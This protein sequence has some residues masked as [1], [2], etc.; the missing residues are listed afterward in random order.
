MSSHDNEDLIDYEDEN[1]LPTNGAAVPS[2]NGAA[3]A[4]A[5][6]GEG[7]KEK[8]NFS[9][10]HS[11]GFRD[12]LLKPELLRAISDLGFEHPSEVQQECIPQAVLG[13]DVL[14]QAK[15]GHGKT[16]VFV[17]ATLQQLEPVNGEVSVLVLCHTRELAFQIKN[18]Y[19]RFAK[20]MPDV[21]VST[22]YGGT[23]VAK[24]SEILRDKTKCP[25][26]VVATPGRLNAL[27]R[28]KVLDAKNVKHFVL[29]ECDKMLEQLD[30][31]R[32]V[33]EIFRATPH[34][35]QVMMF[36]ATLAKEI[37]V[38]CKKFMANPLEIFV[39]DETKLT[40]HGLQQHYVKLE[41]T[42]KN[43]KLNE[44]LD[45]LE[46]NQVVIFVKSVARAIELDKLLVSCNFPSISIHSG[47]QQE[48]RIKRYTAFK[49]FEKRILVATDIFGRGIDVERVNIVVNY[50]CPP[51]A[52]SYLH[53][54][55][56]AGRFGT[57]GLAIT[58]VS[59]ESDQQVMAAIQSRFEVAVSELPEHIDPASYRASP[60][61]DTGSMTYIAEGSSIK[62]GSNVLAKI[63]PAHSNGSMCL[64]REAH[65]LSRVTSSA[66]A[67][68]TT[69]RLIDFITIPRS[70]GD[71]VVLL[72]SHPGL[73]LLGRYFPPSKVNDFLLAD[74]SKTRTSGANDD[75]FVIDDEELDTL[76]LESFDVMDLASFLEFAIQA[77][78]CLEIIHR[79]GF[80]H[81]E[82]RANAFHLNSHSG[83]VRFVHFGNRAVS[84]EEFG[85]PS[86]LV[87]RALDETEKTKVKEALCYLAPEQT[88]SMEIVNQDHRTDLY[89]L[90]MMFWTLLVGRGMMPFEG[91]P[92]EL[93]HSIVQKRPMPVHEIRRD[94]PMVLANIIDKLLAKSPDSR[95]QSAYGL[96]A[97]LLE[98]QRRLLAAVSSVLGQSYELIPSFDIATQDRYM[99]FTIPVTL[100]GR[101]K[102]L[103]TIRH[104][105]KH[106]TT[107]FSRHFSASRGVL[108]V[109]SAG[110]QEQILTSNNDKEDIVTDTDSD[111]SVSSLGHMN[112]EDGAISPLT[113]MSL[114]G[115]HSTAFSAP[116]AVDFGDVSKR[117]ANKNKSHSVRAHT[118]MVV[119]HP[120]D[121]VGKSSLVLANQAKWRSH[122]LWGQAKFQN[123]D[124]APFAAL[125]GCLSSVLRQL[126][127]FHTDLHRFVNALKERLGPQLQNIPLLYQGTPELRDILGIFDIDIEIPSNKDRLATL[128]L[129]ARSL[130]LIETLINSRSRMLIFGTLRSDVSEEYMER[131]RNMCSNKGRTTWV[132]V[133]PLSFPALGSL[134]SKTLHQEEES[135]ADLSRFIYTA[136]CGNAFVARNLLTTFQ[137]QHYITFD[138]GN[139][140]WN[141]DIAAI[142][143]SFADQKTVADPADGSFLLNHFRELPEEAQKYLLWASFFGATFKVTEV[144]L[145]MDWERTNDNGGSDEDEARSVS[146]AVST[147]QEQEHHTTSARGS[148]RGLQA[149]ISEG[150]L[151]Q[152][153]RDMCSFAHDRYRQAVQVEAN[154]LPGPAISNMSFRIFTELQSMLNGK[155]FII[156]LHLLHDH[157]KWGE[158]LNVL[159][160]AGDS[161]WA[162]GAH[163]LALQAFS[164]AK[165]LLR[166]NAWDDNPRR[167]LKQSDIL[168]EECVLKAEHPEDKGQ[169]LRLRANNQWMRNN[170][171][172]ALKDTIYALH[173]LGVDVN[174]A[175]SIEEA[176][177]M[178][179]EVK[180][181]VLAMGYDKIIRIPRAKDP[182]TDLAVALLND[183]GN[184]AY[185]SPGEGFA[186][187]IG[188]TGAI[189]TIRVALQ[190]G[191]SPGTPLGF[192]WALGAAAER[193][194]LF[195][196]STD[197]GKLALRIADIHGGSFDKCRANVLFAAL[198]APYDNMHIRANLPRLEEALKYGHSAGDRGFTSFASIHTIIT[199][200]YVCDHL[201]EVV[202][203]AEE[204]VSDIELWTPEGEANILAKDT[205]SVETTFDTNMCKEADFIR[206]IQK[207]SGNLGLSMSWYNA[208][209]VVALFCVGHAE[210]SAELGFSVYA[211]RSHH[212][213]HRHP[214]Y[215]AFFH[216]LALIACL[217]EGKTPEGQ[218][219]RYMGQLRLNQSY[220]RKWL[221]PSPINTSTWVALVDAELASL[222]GD[223]EALKLYDT[224]VK[225]AV[226]DNWH[227]EEGWALYMDVI[228]FET[229]LRVWVV[230]YNVVVYCG[231]HNGGHKVLYVAIQ[232][233]T[234]LASFSGHPP[235]LYGSAPKLETSEE[236]EISSLSASDLASILKWSKD[237]SSD[238][239]LSSALQRLT[240]IATE[241]SRSQNTCLVITS[242]SG[243][244][245]VATS[246][247]TPEMC[248]VYEN[249]KSVRSISDPLQKA[250]IQ[251][252]ICLPIFSNRGQTYGAIYVSSKY[253][254]SQNT[255]TILTLLC[256]QAS[257]SISS[258]LLF[259]SVQAGTRENLKMI[260][261]QR[262]ALET[263]RKSR[264][265]ALK[266]TKVKIISIMIKSNFL[267]SM[268]HELR[269]PFSSFYGLLDLL[270]GTE[271]N[272]GQSEI[273]Y[274]KLEASAVKLEFS[275]FPVENIIADCMELLSPM[276][277]KKLDLSFNI[278]PDV[279]PWIVSDYARIRQVLMN[280]IGNAVKFTASG[281]VTVV[282]SVEKET[283]VMPPDIE[284]KFTIRDTGIGLSPSAVDLLFVP[285][286]QADNSSTRRFGGT[287]LGLSI[288]RQLVK[289][290]G[291]TIGVQ[292]E[293]NSGSV[294]WFTL[295]VKVYES[296]DSRKALSDIERLQ[297]LLK[298]PQTP[299]ILICS[300]SYATS[301][302]LKMM[303][304]GF[305][306]DSVQ[307]MEEVKYNLR[308]LCS[309][310]LPLDFLVLDDQSEKLADDLSQYIVSLDNKSLEDTKI[311]HLYTPTTDTLSGP[312]LSNST[313]SG[314]LRM[315]KPPRRARLLQVLAKLKNIPDIAPATEFKRAVEDSS[316]NQ[317]TLYG[318]V[319]IAEDN[320]V[321]Q[322]LLVKQ[323]ER[324]Q[325][326]VTATSNGEEA[327]K[328]WETREP[329]FFT[330]A[331]FDHRDL[332]SLLSMFGTSPASSASGD[333][334]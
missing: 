284:L 91:R 88:G 287:G 77:T 53:R 113:K 307:D 40:L 260:S 223:P 228:L 56:R 289:L 222:T 114:H 36:S 20:Y 204:C 234:V 180:N 151:V 200:L 278:E 218:R 101:E 46:F 132:Q 211:T 109:S 62:D 244:Y 25:H 248:V 182:R 288:S 186:D 17:L 6:D 162:R 78:H 125:L 332:L 212:P 236:Q 59:S 209:K 220:V 175:P 63:A 52:D 80:T 201:S 213:N 98:C 269:T 146:R 277:A 329:G 325:L 129:R 74:V 292:S 107:S 333:T 194:G 315:T 85:G 282:C 49:A 285:F 266:A 259:R 192:F 136:S 243:E 120:G 279:P 2:S 142:E 72:L 221:S 155:G 276:A 99:A 232:T 32:D 119:G 137:R 177:Q 238:I 191:M 110:S 168:A 8:K 257:I 22:F 256:Q 66:D 196:F 233:D 148:M 178:F 291:G 95:Y 217:R 71:C 79:A 82:V 231:S 250:V 57:K 172:A 27:A 141:H 264:E 230:N 294:F 154:D 1:D 7:D 21:R 163:E 47:L 64:E 330:V 83:V 298:T 156:C 197:L 15:S 10:I 274:S 190:R 96:K 251:H 11:T 227:L 143:A 68:S 60:W 42:G 318:N 89:S 31:R 44:L 317:R 45:T 75:I 300:Q 61:E 124:S 23:P 296:E 50:D 206:Y 272:P 295:P 176:D 311:I 130:D 247:V 26:I 12:F 69:L 249:Q 267:A 106:T 30:M 303:L 309:L 271:L 157:P 3:L 90:G 202:L 93:L 189:Q 321:A 139:N 118:I 254:F 24:D 305:Q 65:I 58:C 179:E 38:T 306:V 147:L 94:V 144:A 34:H 319:L 165:S 14:C 149:A 283:N 210:A 261:A 140:R 104:V 116:P 122:G 103:E 188:L 219:D 198:V 203:A 312:A 275:G 158:L 18:E 16:A 268:S 19:T 128:E 280:L 170:Y 48:E 215:A 239:N 181:E 138:W 323:L 316:A 174:P 135:C 313:T 102:E 76:E 281:S 184:N 134:V 237:I 270:S 86:T 92:L 299:R 326:S 150:W 115:V 5:V 229:V 322:N 308:S 131:I 160:D 290:M 310:A 242:P 87:I 252:V 258:A 37:R 253:A 55:G 314:V 241:A 54:V 263:A 97:D 108:G 161:A 240:E 224:A 235:T 265:H 33:Q 41:E 286:Q 195:R 187:V 216:S 164:S 105:I 84:L 199:R 205:T 145:L 328:E 327:I 35:K 169:A 111:R 193:R 304:D 245:T 214:R 225:L 166:D 51:D 70:S 185:W 39:D 262:E 9:G 301:A 324:Y 13:M 4:T 73:N 67:L 152:R 320:P 255:V 127:I 334:V 126:M 123:A 183:A 331:L 121:R 43:R 117:M 273:D 226:N 167:D 29:D 100:F 171:A 159:I 81:R 153:A 173:A 246:M 207:T 208:F 297:S 28:D 293:L 302:L 112:T 133:E